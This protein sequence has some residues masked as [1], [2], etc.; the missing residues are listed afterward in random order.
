MLTFDLHTH[1]TLSFDGKSSAEDMVKRAIE[2]GIKH[3]ALTDHVDL[4][5]HADPDFDLEATVNGAKEQIPALQ[6][7]YSDR[8]D[9]LYGVELGQAVHEPELAKKL[10]DEN[11]YDFVIGSIHN[12]RGYDD[13]Y[14]LDYTKLDVNALLD[15]YFAELL[16]T[17]ETA[18]FDVMAH[19]TYPLRYIAGDFGI[20]ID[21]SRFSAVIDE[22][23]C[24][25]IKRGKGIEINTSGLRQKLGRTMPDADIIRRFRGLGGEILTI[26]S[27]A[28]CTDDLGK[29]ISEGIN[30][31][32]SSGFD[33]TAIFKQRQPIFIKI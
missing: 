11:D 9:I 5:D 13:F 3:Y 4:G 28:H 14:F 1:C 15:A 8:I 33:K 21:M 17:A 26:G 10:L 31:A 23:L 25:L 19:I 2:L 6:K 30:T 18:D 20:D 27:D 29:G 32:I 16:E 12:I 22:I 24:A 7:K